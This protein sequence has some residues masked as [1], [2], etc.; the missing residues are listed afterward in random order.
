M[1]AVHLDKQFG[2]VLVHDV[3][4]ICGGNES[5]SYASWIDH[6]QLRHYDKRKSPTW[7]TTV[8]L[9]LPGVVQTGG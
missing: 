4:I 1:A 2:R 8:G 3:A 5:R 6:G 7:F 9:Q